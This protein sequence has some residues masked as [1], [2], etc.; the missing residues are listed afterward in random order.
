MP[1]G[2]DALPQLNLEVKASRPWA[3][4]PLVAGVVNQCMS[5]PRTI[6]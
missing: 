4:C 5:T 6:Q 3:D 1:T 2:S